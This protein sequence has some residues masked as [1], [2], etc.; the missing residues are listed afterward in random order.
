MTK[1]SQITNQFNHVRR[2]KKDETK[3]DDGDID[4]G[5]AV[6]TCESSVGLFAIRRKISLLNLMV[7]VVGKQIDK[8]LMRNQN[9]SFSFLP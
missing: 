3:N 1:A 7:V 2:V 6:Q 8:A 4:L 5:R 9:V